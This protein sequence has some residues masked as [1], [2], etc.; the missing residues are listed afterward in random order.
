MKR[1]VAGTVENIILTIGTRSTQ[2]YGFIFKKIKYFQVE[3][4]NPQ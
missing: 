1:D 3:A 4:I 2:C